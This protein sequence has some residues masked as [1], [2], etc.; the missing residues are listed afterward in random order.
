MAPATPLDRKSEMTLQAKLDALRDK[1][2][3]HA[4]KDVLESLHRAIDELSASGAPG[5][6]LKSGAVAPAFSL[7][8]PDG[9]LVSSKELL[10]H[11][12]LIVTF[13]RGAWC[14]FC[15][16]DLKALEEARPE[17]EARNATL[18]AISQTNAANSRKAQSDNNLGF[19]ILSDKGGEVGAAFGVRWT[20]PEYL[21]EAHRKVG[22]PLPMF[23]GEE[24]WTLAMPARYVI[25]Q[26][27]VIAYA[28]VNADY[29]VRPEPSDMFPILDRLR[30]A[31]VA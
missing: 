30:R 7:P 12:T 26:D 22:A 6:A 24:S 20:L 21:R 1:F 27:G 17:L 14:P 15:N 9:K 10:A 2:E 13:Y 29:R 18:V 28:E 11:K 3:P 16:L 31:K 4:P 23:N 25:G 8:D 19:P 5:R